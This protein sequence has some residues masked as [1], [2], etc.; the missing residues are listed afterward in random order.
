[1]RTVTSTTL[2]QALLDPSDSRAWNRFHER[3][4]PMVKSFA[5]KQGLNESD[6]E[7]AA[8]ETVMAFMER[9]GKGGFDRKKG[10]LRGWLFS[11][12]YNKAVDIL[13]KRRGVDVISARADGTYLLRSIPS[14]EDAETKW[15]A[16]WQD[17]VLQAC[18]AEVAQQVKETTYQA[19]NLYVLRQLPVE[20]VAEQLGISENA[21]YIAKNRVISRI[22]EIMPPMEDI[23]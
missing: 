12:A 3:Y 7:D 10:R 11:I 21:V 13:R 17:F 6:A 8:Q 1:M 16:E 20:L 15:D 9:Y 5:R 4:W 23:W 19:F 18:L 14:R 2:L 22:R